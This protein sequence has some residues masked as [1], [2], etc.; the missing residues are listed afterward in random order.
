MKVLSVKRFRQRRGGRKL[1]PFN[2]IWEILQ[3]VGGLQ[4]RTHAAFLIGNS[5]GDSLLSRRIAAEDQQYD[6]AA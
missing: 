4:L 5:Q 3:G 1:G 6:R 2:L